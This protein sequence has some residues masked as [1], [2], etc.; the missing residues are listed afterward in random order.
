MVLFNCP[1]QNGYFE[2]L[3]KFFCTCVATKPSRGGELYGEEQ[4]GKKIQKISSLGVG[5]G[6]KNLCE[7]QSRLAKMYKFLAKIN[8]NVPIPR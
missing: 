1:D 5:W 6:N 7:A 8:Q 4:H 3:A 2:T